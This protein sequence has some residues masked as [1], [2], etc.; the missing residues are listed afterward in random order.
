M[1]SLKP[2]VVGVAFVLG[3]ASFAGDEVR[4]VLVPTPAEEV[5]PTPA[6]VP[7]PVPVPVP[8]PAPK[9]CVKTY[10]ANVYTVLQLVNQCGQTVKNS[11]IAGHFARKRCSNTEVPVAQV[12]ASVCTQET[13]G[14][15][16]E[17]RDIRAAR[18]DCSACTAQDVRYLIEELKSGSHRVRVAA[19]VSLKRCGLRVVEETAC[20]NYLPPSVIYY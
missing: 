18:R 6:P 20:V 8:A 7:V 17:V 14:S 13:C 5:M 2:L 4:S 1:K 3:S 10:R 19:E 16:E 9:A 15:R 12:V 11:G